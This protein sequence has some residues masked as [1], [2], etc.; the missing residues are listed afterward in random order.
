MDVTDLM[1]GFRETAR[2]LWNCA[3]RPGADWDRVD[4]FRSIHQLLFDEMVLRGLGISRYQKGKDE[5]YRFL[6]AIPIADP[7]PIEIHRASQGGYWD[8]PINRLSPK[9]LSLAIIEFFDFDELGYRD[10]VYYR[11][12]VEACR[13][14]PNL[15]GREALLQVQNAKVEFFSPGQ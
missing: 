4:V 1:L 13:D 2:G 10:F 11:V 6:H 12:R 7:I 3:L 15:V 8:D 9:G 5:P 14:H